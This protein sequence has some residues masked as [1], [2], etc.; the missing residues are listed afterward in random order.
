MSSPHSA[1][2]HKITPAM[3]NHRKDR[4]SL[5]NFFSFKCVL[6]DTFTQSFRHMLASKTWQYIFPDR[7]RKFQENTGCLWWSPI[8]VRLALN[9]R[10]HCLPDSAEA[11]GS[12]AELAQQVGKISEHPNKSQ[13]TTQVGDH[14]SHPGQTLYVDSLVGFL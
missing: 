13:P 12:L 11:A 7:F 9:L 3:H 8:W 6:A 10:F 1:F 5:T 2:N 14:Q 4:M